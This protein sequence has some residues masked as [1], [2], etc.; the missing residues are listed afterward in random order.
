[1]V[2]FIQETL[3][4]GSGEYLRGKVVFKCDS[5]AFH[6]EIILLYR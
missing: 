6:S 3:K 1:M 5:G 4:F 2:L